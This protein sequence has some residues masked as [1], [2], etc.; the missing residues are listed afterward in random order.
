M[1][2][3]DKGRFLRSEMIP[4]LQGIAPQAAPLWGK[5][6]VQQMIE[7]LGDVVRIA[8]GALQVPRLFTSKEDLPK[9][10]AFLMSDK[11]FSRNIPNPLLPETPGPVRFADAA[12]ALQKLQQAV[13]EFFA[14]FAA[15]PGLTTLNPFFGPLNFEENVQLL[16]KHVRHHLAQ[17]GV[18]V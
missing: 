18:A 12:A 6:S 1:T 4:L 17:F 3:T 15:N 8:S 2:I 9:M 11:P 5:M 13:D 10:R 7:H 16:H 14:V